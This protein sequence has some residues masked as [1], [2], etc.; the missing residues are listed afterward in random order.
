[1]L[2]C[3]ACTGNPSSAGGQS[4]TESGVPCG[5]SPGGP[6]GLD[7]QL[8]LDL[9]AG[10]SSGAA[11]ATARSLLEAEIAKGTRTWNAQL[12]MPAGG[13]SHVYTQL[14]LSFS[15]EPSAN[16]WPTK[17]PGCAKS[18]SI[19]GMVLHLKTADGSFDELV[20]GTVDGGIARDAI[21]MTPVYSAQFWGT[22]S[23]TPRGSYDIS[24]LMK[25]FVQPVI[26]VR[27]SLYG[28]WGQILALEANDP[29]H[30]AVIAIWDT[31]LDAQGGTGGGC[32]GQGGG[33]GSNAGPNN[34]GGTS[35][36]CFN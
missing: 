21:S 20:S 12:S 23:G 1:M 19:E 13:D 17:D 32:P 2:A 24:A 8:P 3:I 16:I 10:G 6:V 36:L 11:S 14:S 22:L 5:K 25:Q 34:A 26:Y 15:G 33:G 31:S 35:G 29:A 30:S 7:E 28:G 4:G 9:Q 18:L 27:Y